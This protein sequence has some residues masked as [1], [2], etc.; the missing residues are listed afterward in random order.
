MF[1]ANQTRKIRENFIHLLYYVTGNPEVLKL[2]ISLGADVCHRDVHGNSPIY[3]ASNHRCAESVR[4]CIENGAE[5]NMKTYREGN[6]PLHEASKHG[7]AEIIKILY[8]NGALL[9]IKNHDGETPMEFGLKKNVL[10]STKA[11]AFL[12]H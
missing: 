3:L 2:L 9:T 12:L 7:N 8:D 1:F 5:L 11:F 10:E 6:T 4:I